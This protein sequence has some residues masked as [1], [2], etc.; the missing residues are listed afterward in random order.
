M[1]KELVMGNG[2]GCV[3]RR[4]W[5]MGNNGLAMSVCITGVFIM[6]RSSV[7]VCERSNDMDVSIYL[8]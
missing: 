7:G 3:V 5:G 1:E 8:S 2:V 4:G 6:I